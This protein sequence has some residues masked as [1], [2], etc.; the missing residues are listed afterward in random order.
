MTGTEDA[1]AAEAAELQYLRRRADE[2][3][4]ELGETLEAFA[5][6]L[7]EDTD[8]GRWARRGAHR[9]TAGLGRAAATAARRALP[10]PDTA[11]RAASVVRSASHSNRARAIAVAA[12]A[13]LAFAAWWW[14]S[15]REHPGRFPARG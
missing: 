6:R 13:G 8:L 12:G 4:A 11:T 5:A 9:A 15:C 14:L 10:G 2:R 7:A 3:R 1:A